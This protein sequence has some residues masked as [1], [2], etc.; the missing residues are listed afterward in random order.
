MKSS[1]VKDKPKARSEG[2]DEKEEEGTGS[3]EGEERPFIPFLP[4]EEGQIREGV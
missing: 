2:S 4:R 1:A 3:C